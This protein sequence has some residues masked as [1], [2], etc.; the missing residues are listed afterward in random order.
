MSGVKSWGHYAVSLGRN[1]VRSSRWKPYFTMYG[2]LGRLPVEDQR[3][4]VPMRAWEGLL[5]FMPPLRGHRS[6][7][8]RADHR[9]QGILRRC[10][11]TYLMSD[12]GLPLYGE[13]TKGERSS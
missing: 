3:L 10:V 8:N 4:S 6:L 13:E 7:W 12:D 11:S 2:P 9:R 1:Q 5:R